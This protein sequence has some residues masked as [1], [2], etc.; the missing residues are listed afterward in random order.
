MENKNSGNRSWSIQNGI[1]GFDV[2]KLPRC[3]AT[4]KST[5]KKCRRAAK[6]GRNF[7]GIHAGLYRPGQKKGTQATLKHGYYTHQALQERREAR[8]AM[9]SLNAV[10]ET[11]NRDLQSTKNLQTQGLFKYEHL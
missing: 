11:I 3:T 1:P 9:N 2:S 10:L 7:C 8:A 6:K 4:A 5:G